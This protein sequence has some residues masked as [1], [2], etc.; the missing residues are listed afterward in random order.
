MSL[1]KYK[2][3]RKF[4][5]T[6][7]PKGEVGKKSLPSFAPRAS[8]GK[9]RFVVQKHQARNLH[10]DFRL[11]MDGV[12]KSWAVPKGVPEKPGVKHLAVAVEDHPVSYANF[13]G[14][15]PEGNYGAG[16]VEIWDQGKYELTEKTEK[17]LKFK[18][19][20]KR[21]RGE[22][23]LFNFKGKNWFMFKIKNV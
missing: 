22:Y 10:Y 3:K 6:P 8:E 1:E 20:G 14:V 23:V 15:I 16:T 5:R 4:D 11:E 13:A 19:T 7:E 2:K 18:L 12:L 21:L 9:H 17:A